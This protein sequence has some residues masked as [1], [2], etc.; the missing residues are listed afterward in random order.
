MT[1]HSISEYVCGSKGLS[2]LETE[3]GED[4][5]VWRAETLES[6]VCAPRNGPGSPPSGAGLCSWL[7][8]Q[9]LLYRGAG[10]GGGCHGAGV[11]IRGKPPSFISAW[12]S[13]SELAY[14]SICPLFCFVICLFSLATRYLCFMLNSSSPSDH[15][16]HAGT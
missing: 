1:S 4:G 16:V 15:A 3:S 9:C 10:G 14:R 6:W 8:Q 5:H 7:I 12:I 11:I 2:C 13:S